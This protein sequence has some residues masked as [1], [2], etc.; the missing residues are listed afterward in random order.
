[1]APAGHQSAIRLRRLAGRSLVWPPDGRRRRA[2]GWSRGLW[3]CCC[4]SQGRADACSARTKSPPPP[5]AT[6]PSATTPWPP[7]SA[8]CAARSAGRACGAT[9]R[10]CRSAGTARSSSCRR[11]DPTRAPH[12]MDRPRPPRWWRR[13]W[14]ALASPLPAAWPRR[15]FASRRRWPRPLG[16]SP[17]HQGFAEALIVRHSVDQGGDLA[18]AKAAARAAVGLDETSRRR[19]GDPGQGAAARGP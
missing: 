10:L 13:G 8:D 1:M 6:A 7:L 18:A 19:L 14:Q 4:C 2:C 17:A 12:P 5:G 16:W 9:L 11:R 15:G 3:T